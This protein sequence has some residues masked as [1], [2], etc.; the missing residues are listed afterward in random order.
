MVLPHRMNKA[1]GEK[2]TMQLQTDL[3]KRLKLF[4]SL[5]ACFYIT[6]QEPGRYLWVTPAKWSSHRLSF[7]Q[8]LQQKP[9]I[10]SSFT[11]DP[12]IRLEWVSSNFPR[13]WVMWGVHNTSHALYTLRMCV[14]LRC[15]PPAE[16]TK[17][18]KHVSSWKR[19]AQEKQH[20]Y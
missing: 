17:V 15:L 6:I 1:G 7:Y 9:E 5:C 11:P 4:H 16:S 2:S 13:L 19:Q 14:H 12:Q 18:K 10:K 8:K 3:K 20:K